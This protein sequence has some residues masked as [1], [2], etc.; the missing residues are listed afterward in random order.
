MSNGRLER[1]TIEFKKIEAKLESLPKIF[2][3]YYYT[4]RAEKKSYR[5]IEEYINS[6][7]HFMIYI[8]NGEDN[9][10]FYQN[11]NTMDIN[12]YMISL[13]TKTV[14]GKTVPTSSGFRANR[15]KALNS[16]FEFLVDTGKLQVNPISKKSRPKITD[17]PSVT[18]LNED[19]IASIIENIKYEAKDTMVN[20]D[21]CIFMLGVTTGLRVAAITQ[22]NIEDIDFNNGTIHVVEKMNKVFDVIIGKNL[23][24]VLKSWICDREKYFGKADTNA[25]FISQFGKRISYD[26]VRKLLIKYTEGATDKKITPHCLRHTCAT[27]LYE[28]T[29]DIYL[30]SAQLHHSNINT[31]MRY[32]EVSNQK[33][34]N[35]ND[36]L[37]GLIEGLE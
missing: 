4:L 11:V 23:M 26:A 30:A 10:A 18:Y 25:L 14:Q 9:Q 29:G 37:E 13:E 17:N 28:K 16:F 6:V 12:K 15:W 20:R 8:T 19:E 1:E 31:T 7:K 27:N 3:E 22:I 34:K 24:N 35:A 5:T 2:T 33:L 21:L 32:A 36:I